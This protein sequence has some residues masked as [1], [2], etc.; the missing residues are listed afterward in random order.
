M[1]R[2]KRPTTIQSLTYSNN[3]REDETTSKN[4]LLFLLFLDRVIKMVIVE[5]PRK[6][7]L[8]PIIGKWSKSGF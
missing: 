4:F 5:K 1:A 8:D 3:S 6:Q 2:R 7:T